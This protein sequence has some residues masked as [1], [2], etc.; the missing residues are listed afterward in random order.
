MSATVTVTLNHPGD[1]VSIASPLDTAVPFPV[2][3]VQLANPEPP[4]SSAQEYA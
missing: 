1:E 2:S 4:T 3:A